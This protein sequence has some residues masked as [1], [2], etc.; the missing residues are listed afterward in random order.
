MK[1]FFSLHLPSFLSVITIV[2]LICLPI[3]SSFKKP[4][5]LQ[6]AARVA[7]GHT[8]SFKPALVELSIGNL[9]TELLAAS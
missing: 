1:V 3:T 9:Q 8:S 4:D 2:R 7:I 5:Y 6:S